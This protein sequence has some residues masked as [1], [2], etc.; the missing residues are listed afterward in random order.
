M[1]VLR[2][3]LMPA[4][5]AEQRKT[6]AAVVGTV[7][8]VVAVVGGLLGYQFGYL[9]PSVNTM[10]EEANAADADAKIVEGIEAETTTTLSLIKPLQDKVNFVKSVQFHNVLVP[11][12]YRNVAK[13]T[14]RKVEY[15]SMAVNGDSLSINAYVQNLSDVGKFYLTLFANPDIKSVSISALPGWPN[16]STQTV[17]LPGEAPLDPNAS[18]FP[19]QVSANLLMP[20]AAPAPPGGGGAAAGGGFG[21]MMGGSGSMMGGAGMRGGGGPMMGAPMAGGGSGAAAG[22][23]GGG[24]QAVD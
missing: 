1:S 5:I 9:V 12:I 16:A 21:G 18:G 10:I 22:S 24:P 7:V 6:K 8:G 2:I 19:L 23:K 3:N 20:V 15:S 4:Y 14:Y 11:Q 17:G 13:Y